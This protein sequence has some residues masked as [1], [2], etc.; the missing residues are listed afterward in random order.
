V[1]GAEPNP[2][3][4]IDRVLQNRIESKSV[5]FKEGFEWGKNKP[6]M[7]VIKD[8][9]AM[10]NSGGGIITIGIAERNG[11]F[12][13]EGVGA[14][15]L[16][17]FDTTRVLTLANNYASP[18]L[19][20]RI[21]THSLPDASRSLVALQVV[22]FSSSPHFCAR[23]YDDPTNQ[24]RKLL[25]SGALYVRTD[26]AESVEISSADQFSDLIEQ[27][28][29]ARQGDVLER[30]RQAITGFSI[31]STG[32]AEQNRLDAMTE[33]LLAAFDNQ[34]SWDDP[35]NPRWVHLMH[36]STVSE[37][38][39]SLAEL[40]RAKDR[41]TR[42]YRMG[43][44]IE[45]DHNIPGYELTNEG[46]QFRELV[47][48]NSRGRFE[49][50]LRDDGRVL[51]ILPSWEAKRLRYYKRHWIDVASIAFNVVAGVDFLIAYFEELGITDE[52]ISWQMRL[53]RINDHYL[54]RHGSQTFL[55]N[56]LAISERIAVWERHHFLEWQAERTTICI[57]MVRH[58]LER[59]RWPTLSDEY[60][61]DL[62]R[63]VSS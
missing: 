46:I 29:R 17:S 49:W 60:I 16:A 15:N 26:A 42:R 1:A 45:E 44:F 48:S 27:V 58:F 5:D 9:L 36:P 50:C 40:E 47:D 25:R 51:A 10:A 38:R 4:S 6:S 52:V 3:F 37:H 62:I 19:R 33:Q 21:S 31:P 2:E 59:F 53:E 11:T 41:A 18:S 23:D 34:T 63:G 13:E 39:L 57:S 35:Q 8:M 43:S 32:T 20:V 54:E 14:E 56:C 7:G 30:I 61:A 24:A 12:V 55:D 28:F 22:P